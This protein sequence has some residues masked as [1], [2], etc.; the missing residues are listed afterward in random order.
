MNRRDLIALVGGAVVGVTLTARAQPARHYRIAILFPASRVSSEP[1]RGALNE[2]LRALGY[3]KADIEIEVRNADGHLERLPD[4]AAELVRL[5]PEVIVAGAPAAVKAAQQATAT[6]PIV[7]VNVADPVGAGFVASLARPGGNVTG[8]ANLAQETVG[9]RLQ[10][11]KTTIPGAVRIAILF[12][13]GNPGNVLQFQAARQAAGALLTDLLSVEARGPDEIEGA[14]AAMTR[15]HSEALFV[16]DDPIFDVVKITGLAASH[17]LP[18]IYQRREYV[19]VGGLISYGPDLSNLY[20]QAAS[21]VDKI[22]KGAKPA[23]LP[24]QQPTK[25]ELVINL[26]T[27]KALGLTVPQLLLAQADEVIE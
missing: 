13:P 23:D 18:T 17:G 22:L 2:G 8:L 27:A 25:Y 11:L 6:I 3:G 26:K 15:A 12:N 1:N 16:A 24:V 19:T 4:L 20:G 5:S 10:L 7:V 14:F 21:Y 9:K